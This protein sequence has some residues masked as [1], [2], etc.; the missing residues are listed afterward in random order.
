MR[1]CTRQDR[2]DLAESSSGPVYTAL[3]YLQTAVSFVF[4][5]GAASLQQCSAWLLSLQLASMPNSRGWSC[6]LL[7][8]THISTVLLV[9]VHVV[10]PHVTFQA[11]GFEK[12]ESTTG[13][14]FIWKLLK[15]LCGLCQSPS[16]WNLTI[17]EDP[18]C[19][20]V[21]MHTYPLCYLSALT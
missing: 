12:I 11:S 18:G 10:Q 13:K 21:G 20:F 17:D 4:T 3:K 19:T 5:V 6:W 16:V 1:A 2:R 8:C 14:P 15:S 7:V 9:S